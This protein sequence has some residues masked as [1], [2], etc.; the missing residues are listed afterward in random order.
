LIA[1]NHALTGAFIGLSISSPV[2]ALPVALLSHFICDAIPHFGVDS[3]F[4]KTTVFRNML[5]VDAVLCVALVLLLG[6]AQPNNWLVAAL[7]AFL[8]TSPDLLWV[9]MYRSAK[10]GKTYVLKGFHKFASDIQWFERPIGG[11]V[12]I[13]WFI[14]GIFLVGTLALG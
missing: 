11:V 5:V 10:Q 4:I 6:F 12:E 14:T 1:T 8:A 9:P 13:V 7:C 3:S 2:I